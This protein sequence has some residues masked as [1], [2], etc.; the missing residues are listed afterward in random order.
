L[1]GLFVTPRKIYTVEAGG[2]SRQIETDAAAIK[3]AM[4]TLR[5]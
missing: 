5:P 3:A 1:L 2:Q 4:A